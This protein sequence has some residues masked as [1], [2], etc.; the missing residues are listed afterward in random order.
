MPGDN[1]CC[2]HSLAYI[3]HDKNTQK[4]PELRDLAAQ[5]IASDPKTYNEGI[6]GM[7]NSSY[8]Q[9]LL[10]P[11]TWGGAV[12]VR[13][14]A[15]FYQI[16]IC[17][18]DLQTGREDHFGIDKGYSRRGFLFYTGNHYDAMAYAKH[19]GSHPR[20]DQ[21]LFNSKD[22]EIMKKARDFIKYENKELLKS[23]LL[24]N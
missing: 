5:L 7:K 19:G 2:F 12:E 24:N 21:V 1:S 4:G 9:H 23:K 15:D 20:D 13:A 6:L 17:L 22:D 8:V 18:M 11:D 10:N 3:L 14:M 16:E